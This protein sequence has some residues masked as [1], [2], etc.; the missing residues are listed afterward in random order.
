MEDNKL[1]KLKEDLKSGRIKA[2]DLDEKTA[3]EFLKFMKSH[4]REKMDGISKLDKE[5]KKL[6]EETKELNKEAQELEKE[7]AKLDEE[8]QKVENEVAEILLTTEEY[9]AKLN[10]FNSNNE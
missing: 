3:Q 5:I 1:L 4:I 2:E 8:T 9:K 7:N 6:E 10:K